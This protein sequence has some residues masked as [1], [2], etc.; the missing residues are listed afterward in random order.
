MLRRCVLDA[1][2]GTDQ[3]VLRL[4]PVQYFQPTRRV[5]RMVRP[6]SGKAQSLPNLSWSRK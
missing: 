6:I 5:E 2:T 1:Y 3:N 4:W